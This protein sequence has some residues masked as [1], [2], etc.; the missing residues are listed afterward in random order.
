MQH[1][2]FTELILKH[3]SIY[4]FYNRADILLIFEN[5]DRREYIGINHLGVWSDLPS[6]NIVFENLIGLTMA[7]I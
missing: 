5:R 4:G 2:H 7:Q 1:L 6:F 3:N